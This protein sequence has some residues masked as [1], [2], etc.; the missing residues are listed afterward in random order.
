MIEKFKITRADGRSNQQ[1]VIDLVCKAD[2]GALYTY[3]DISEAL[4]VGTDQAFVSSR[5]QAIVLKSQP[6]LLKEHQRALTN[7]AGFGYKMALAKDHVGL[8]LIRHRKADSQLQ[9]GLHLLRHVRW[10]EMDENAR[11]AHTGM[12]LVTEALYRNQKALERRQT[13][14]E[15]VLAALKSRV[16]GIA[17]AR[18]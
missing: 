3:A 4:A 13:R 2:P 5:V 15:D 10:N 16:D 17:G 12:L 8:S 6:R 1:V 18:E 7:L 11:T 14:V 9:K